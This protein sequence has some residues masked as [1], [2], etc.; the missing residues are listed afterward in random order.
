MAGGILS[1]YIKNEDE[2]MH[3]LQD[4][5]L[6][7]E[8]KWNGGRLDARNML[9]NEYDEYFTDIKSKGTYENGKLKI[10]TLVEQ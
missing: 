5:D 6:Q 8:K 9:D 2:S 7:I 1:N 10:K 4:T 3:D